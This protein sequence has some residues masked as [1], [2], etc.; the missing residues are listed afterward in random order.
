[1]DL[2]GV[3]LLSE[4]EVASRLAVAGRRIVTRDVFRKDVATR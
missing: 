2:H 4:D 3:L 1:M